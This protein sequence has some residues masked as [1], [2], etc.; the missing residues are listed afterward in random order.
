[1][2]VSTKKYR[3]Y[4]I[5]YSHS[6]GFA[7]CVITTGG[8]FLNSNNTKELMEEIISNIIEASEHRYSK[9]ELVL[10]SISNFGELDELPT[11]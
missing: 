10:L 9:D 8:D 7:S 1:M 2:K 5:S 11:M 6:R 4:L 3:R